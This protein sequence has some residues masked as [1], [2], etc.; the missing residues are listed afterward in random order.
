MAELRHTRPFSGGLKMQPHKA[1]S[2]RGPIARLP[3]PSRLVIAMHQH[4]GPP[5]RP[6]VRP[7]ELVRRGELIGAAEKP[8]S[9]AVH[10]SAA[11]R[12][13]ALEERLVPTGTGLVS[14]ICVVV[15]TDSDSEPI[16]PA[17]GGWPDETAQ[18]LRMIRDAGIVGLGGA[19]FSTAV[20]LG[21]TRRCTTLVLNGAECEPFISCDDMLMREHAA[22][23]L[24]GA[25]IM[26]ELLRAD[27]C[28]VAI[29][30]DK[31]LALD[32]MRAA[33]ESV[34]DARFTL[35]SLPTVYPAG[36][37][38]Q[39]IQSV[40][41]TEVPAGHYPSDIGVVCQNVGTAHALADYV[42]HGRPLI[43]RIV[44]MTGHGIKD[45]QNVE[46]PIGASLRDVVEHCGGL[47]DSAAQL[48]LG[49][50]MMGYALPTDEI[51]VTK[52]TNCIIALAAQETGLGRME[53]PCI[54]CA[55][56]AI[57]C[58]ARLLP[59]ALLRAARPP[60]L[61]ELASLGIDDCI[62]CGCCDV[63]CPSQIPLTA[64][65]RV[66][67]LE[68]AAYRERL[69]RASAADERYARHLARTADAAEDLEREQQALQMP[70]LGDA[71]SRR[72]AV[73]AAVARARERRDGSDSSSR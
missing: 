48:I 42:E 43:S 13:I 9:V 36:G 70:M 33:M 46:V 24:R 2:T 67:K 19:A 60:D 45:P 69:S 26:L 35:A 3:T 72:A 66:G 39:L 41:G 17:R 25:Q 15:A 49:G 44:T 5:A 71:A 64:V 10:A 61:D 14:S 68:L 12:V 18:R 20:K 58:P 53:W 59:Q 40:L 29:E 11:G 37:E 21:P 65:F 7:G 51:P 16:V 54:R 6:I 56:C 32:A 8:G 63:A 57:A 47:L 55:E 23:I 28:I 50:N 31:A 38:R 22:E 27:A 52:S 34:G 62:E 30:R 1:L 4:A 73:E